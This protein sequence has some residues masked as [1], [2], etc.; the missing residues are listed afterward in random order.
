MKRLYAVALAAILLSTF[1][2]SPVHASVDDFIVSDFQTDYYL[3]K[4]RED[5]SRL[6]TIE[7]ITAEF[8]MIDQNHGIERALPLV[9]DG[10]STHLKVTS[11][12]DAD[13]QRRDYS[14][15][16]SNDHVVLRVGQADQYVHGTQVYVITYEQQ[17]V[18]QLFADSGH[19]EFYW[20]VNGTYWR[21]PIESIVARIHIDESLVDSLSGPSACYV[22]GAGGIERCDISRASV[23]SGDMMTAN[24]TR[25]LRASENMTFAIEFQPGTFAA[26]Q[27]SLW[28]NIVMIWMAVSAATMVIAAGL[29]AWFV[30]RFYRVTGRTNEIGTIVPEYLPPR[31]ASVTTS[32]QVMRGPRAVMTAQL[33]DLAVRHYI[34]IY[35]VKDKTL[36]A[37]AEYEIEIV[38][39][40]SGLKWEEQEILKDIFNTTLTVGLRLNLKTLKSGPGFALRT[41]DN[42]QG[43]GSRISGEYALKERT[44]EQMSWFRRAAAITLLFGIASL[45]FALI[46][47]A[48]VAFMLS[49]AAWSLTDK[50]LTL[51]RYLEGLKLYI[52]VAE[53]ERINMLQSPEGAE[54]V[55]S[56]VS[57]TDSAQ[58]VKLYERVLPYAVLFGQ[59]KAWGKQLGVYYEQVNTQP[60]W[61]NSNSGVFNAAVFASAMNNFATSTT[62]YAS[63]SSA[64]SSGSGGGGS[65]GGGGGGG[66]GGGW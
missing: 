44:S 9:Y 23:E 1:F 22:G 47:A 7:R 32:S 34:R 27:P 31:D 26:Y 46:I 29:I 6:K 40:P 13:G 54:K 4:T 21:V 42:D 57:G 53:Q 38:K 59:E 63:S 11:V 64:S 41:A 45:S 62:S 51:R 36:F 58:L 33:L 5:R 50:G 14:T 52:Q 65:S 18:T 56:V 66:G 19:D 48:G 15:I 20:D 24:S 8:P 3:T 30:A 43:L 35:E 17:D 25:P 2:I 10:H 55:A 49:F 37:P 12:T 16:D 39:D 60:D 61:Y 28:E